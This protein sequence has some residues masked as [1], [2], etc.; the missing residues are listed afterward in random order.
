MFDYFEKLITER[1][2][3][4]EKVALTAS[5]FTEFRRESGSSSFKKYYYLNPVK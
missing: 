4:Y 5:A 1:F 3:W 2:C